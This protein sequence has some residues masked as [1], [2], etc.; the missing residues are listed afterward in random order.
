MLTLNVVAVN[1]IEY[2]IQLL[3]NGEVVWSWKVNGGFLDE[4]VARVIQ[5]SHFLTQIPE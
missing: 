4:D 2:S 1:E 3:R 5:K